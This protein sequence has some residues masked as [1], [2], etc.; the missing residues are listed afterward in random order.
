MLR[1]IQIAVYVMHR[2]FL[3]RFSNFKPIIHVYKYIHSF[4]LRFCVIFD[5]HDD[6]EMTDS[7][8]IRFTI[9]L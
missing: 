6:M 7:I 9:C 1:I 3:N 4:P 5:D 8:F 2:L